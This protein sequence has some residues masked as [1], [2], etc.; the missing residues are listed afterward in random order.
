M[1]THARLSP[2]DKAWPKCPGSVREQ[3]AYPDVA[4]EAAID[5]TGSHLLLETCLKNGVS[6][7]TYIGHIL[8]ENHEDKPNGWLIDA[9]RAKRVQIALDYVTN[10]VATLKQ[11]FPGCL[12]TVESETKANPGVLFGRDDWY[13]TCDITITVHNSEVFGPAVLHLEAVDYKD[14]V[15]FVDAK[16]NTQL[17]SY[18]GGKM[19]A[20]VSYEHGEVFTG[21]DIERVQAVIVQ[22]KTGTAIRKSDPVSGVDFV[23]DRLIPLSQAAALTDDPN[24]P[25]I[26]DDKGGDDYCRWCKH[27][28]NCSALADKKLH[29][30][31]AALQEPALEG[32]LFEGLGSMELVR[33]LEDSRLASLYDAYPRIQAVF[34]EISAELEKRV[35]ERGVN[36]FEMRPGKNS[37]KWAYSAAEIEKKLR[38]K[39]LKAEDMYETSLKSPAAILKL[40]E[41]KLTAQQKIAVER[42][43]VVNM[44]GEPKLTRVSFVKENVT[45]MFAELAPPAESLQDMF[46][47][48]SPAPEVSFDSIEESVSF[49]SI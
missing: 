26:P 32:S 39:K 10:R 43:L 17:D 25:L 15:G 18:L 20:A 42:E 37:R 36:G 4:G 22:P 1:S 3:A 46:S 2:S 34:A 13:G 12:V 33:T 44:P 14:G 49:D 16:F 9:E 19:L 11:E 47:E 21:S 40:P 5:G 28:K 7:S 23:R 27:R 8:G 41:D 31:N 6:A 38:N 45:E 29:E 48:I 24:A 30:A 35:K